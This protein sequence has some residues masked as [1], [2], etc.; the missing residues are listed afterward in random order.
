MEILYRNFQK[1]SGSYIFIDNEK[2]DLK[3]FH[4]ENNFKSL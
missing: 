1:G 3:Q 2:K 4:K